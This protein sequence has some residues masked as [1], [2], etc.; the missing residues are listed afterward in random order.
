MSSL[1]RSTSTI[2]RA[3]TS[4]FNYES[5]YEYWVNFSETQGEE[6]AYKALVYNYYNNNWYV[7]DNLLRCD[8]PILINDKMYCFS[9][10]TFS[11]FDPTLTSDIQLVEGIE[12]KKPIYSTATTA[13]IAYVRDWSL[14]S[15]QKMFVTLSNSMTNNSYLKVEAWTVE[16]PTPQEFEYQLFAGEPP[17]TI[18]EELGINDFSLI[19]FRFTSDRIDEV[20]TIIKHT[21]KLE[22]GGDIT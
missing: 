6:I 1:L 10:D 11:Y 12:V 19:K 9:S 15:I 20:C 17:T 8:V 22:Y 16:D 4:T 7:C 3:I 21:V 5:H 14:K 13:W 2:T 18:F